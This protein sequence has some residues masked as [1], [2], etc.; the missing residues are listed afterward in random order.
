MSAVKVLMK[1]LLTRLPCGETPSH[2]IRIATARSS[3]EASG[4]KSTYSDFEYI[5]F[6]LATHLLLGRVYT[7]IIKVPFASE[8]IIDQA[9]CVGGWFPRTIDP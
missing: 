5:F 6:L 2:C 8:L 3:G 7:Q 9:A 1:G 4:V